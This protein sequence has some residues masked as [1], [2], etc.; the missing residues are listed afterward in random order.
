MTRSHDRST[1][2][3]IEA[4]LEEH[5]NIKKLLHVLQQELDVFDHSHSPDYEI[6]RALIE[7]FLDYPEGYHHPKEDILFE[8]LKLRDPALAKRVGDVEDEHEIET[9]RLEKFAQAVDDVLAGREILRQN[10][11]NIVHDFIEHQRKHMDKEELMLFPAALGALKP[12][13]WADIDARLDDRKDLLFDGAGQKKFQA[14][15]K[16]ILRWE[17]E[18]QAHRA[19]ASAHS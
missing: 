17:R 10:F 1:T 5:R 8:K 11:H 7:Y 12:E 9:K 14:L 13:D 6:L 15:Q 2:R 19:P 4:L 16:T 3:I 18:T